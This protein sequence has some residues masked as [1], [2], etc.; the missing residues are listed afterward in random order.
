VQDPYPDFGFFKQKVHVL[1]GRKYSLNEIEN[2]VVRPRF[3]DPRIHAALNCAS[4]SCP[5]LAPYAFTG[6]KL[7]AQLDAVMRDF[8]RD[9]A[10][11]AIGPGGVKLSR[12]FEW[13]GKDFEPAGGVAAYLAKYLEPA[14]AELLK[15]APKIEYL[16]YDWRL[17]GK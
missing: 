6:A 13:Y 16:E 5:P 4:V 8:A 1:G 3:Q 14:D 17:N 10:R 12:I 7:D 2:D 15:K 9:R 11:N